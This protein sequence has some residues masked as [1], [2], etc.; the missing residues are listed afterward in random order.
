MFGF[1]SMPS[2]DLTVGDIKAPFFNLLLFIKLG[3]FIIIQVF[4]GL[5]SIVLFGNEFLS[6]KEIISCAD[7][8]TKALFA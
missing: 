6:V 8:C 4:I 3:I 2:K 5:L 1:Y 7:N